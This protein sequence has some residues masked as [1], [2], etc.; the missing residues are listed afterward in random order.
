MAGDK[1]SLVY[2]ICGMNRL[3]TEAEM[4]YGKTAG[5]LRVICEV[6]LSLLVGIIADD[7]NRIFVGAD[8]SVRADTPEFAGDGP[9]RNGIRILGIGKRQMCNVVFDADC[10]VIQ[11]ILSVKIAEDGENVGGSGVFGAE[12]VTTADYDS[13]FKRVPRTAETTSR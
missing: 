4:R 8:G 1:V 13:I 2:I 11:R 6:S 10:E 5:L 7:F 3:V 12:T 9:G